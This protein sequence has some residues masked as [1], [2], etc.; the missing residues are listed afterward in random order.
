MCC[1]VL[2]SPELFFVDRLVSMRLFAVYVSPPLSFRFIWA[3]H[4]A[5][6]LQ[7]GMLC[8]ALPR[9]FCGLSV[10]MC[11]GACRPVCT[12]VGVLRAVL[13]E[14][15]SCV[16]QHVCASGQWMCLRL[17]S[18]RLLSHFNSWLPVRAVSRCL[19]APVRTYVLHVPERVVC[20][21]LSPWLGCASQC[22]FVAA[23]LYVGSS[24]VPSREEVCCVLA[25][26]LVLCCVALDYPGFGG[27]CDFLDRSGCN[28]SACPRALALC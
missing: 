10:L 17:S 1:W 19:S 5:E 23:P 6:F 20:W 12:V 24:C 7:V 25:C 26:H 21:R 28:R 16:W 2:W 3:C 14:C 18:V 4:V 9:S 22:G 11:A 15:M 27:D 13:A 8:F